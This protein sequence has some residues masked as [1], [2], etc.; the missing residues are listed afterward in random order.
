MKPT[1]CKYFLHILHGH[2]SGIH[3]LISLL[4][5]DKDVFCFI[6]TGTMFQ[7]FGSKYETVSK[8]FQTAFAAG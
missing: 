7:I 2:I 5:E 4:K 8:P 6:G 1:P 3:C